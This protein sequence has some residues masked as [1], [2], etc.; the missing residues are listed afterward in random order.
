MFHV[1][2]GYLENASHSGRDNS[3]FLNKFH[4]ETGTQLKYINMGNKFLEDDNI[5][6]WSKTSKTR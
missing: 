4:G 3:H 2:P 1:C 5:S 6:I